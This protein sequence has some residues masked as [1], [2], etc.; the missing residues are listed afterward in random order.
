MLLL[1]GML[2]GYFSENLWKLGDSMEYV[3][4]LSGHT[5]LFVFI[6]PLIFE[7]SYSIDVFTFTQS[8]WQIMLLALPGVAMLCVL[9]AVII[10]YILQYDFDWGEA[11]TIGAIL[12]ATDPVAVVALLK[13]LGTSV[14]FNILLEGESLL[15]DGTA[16]V[17]FWVFMDMVEVGSFEI[18][19]FF[20]RLFRLSV[21][22]PAVGLL[23]ALIFYHIMKSF[24]NHT[25]YFVIFTVLC[26]YT[27]FY[28]CESAFL[29]I[30]VS[31][32]LALVVLGIY[33]SAKLK[34][35]VVGTLEES[36]EVIWHFLAYV[37]ETTLFFLTGGYLG[38]FF[39]SDEVSEL[40]GVSDIWKICV[41]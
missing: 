27:T 29:E 16:T 26:A 31:G 35:R 18:G 4:G 10:R 25:F 1:M 8:M 5:L 37:L 17:F 14:K 41:F 6:P 30:K 22:G 32:I 39:A 23:C 2:I 7:S 24:L 11:L 20:E 12:A 33:L 19:N 21:G 9:I 28:I 40:L 15:N 36:V 34:G 38:I 13:E 3:A